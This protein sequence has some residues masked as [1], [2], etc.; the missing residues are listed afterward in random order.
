MQD[1]LIQLILTNYQG[2]L[3]LNSCAFPAAILLDRPGLELKIDALLFF[4]VFINI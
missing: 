3:R 2:A 4:S 1:L